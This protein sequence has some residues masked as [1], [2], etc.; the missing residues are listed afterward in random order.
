MSN[1]LTYL[2][3]IKAIKYTVLLYLIIA[4]ADKATMNGNTTPR[5]AAI[6]YL[7]L[8]QIAGSVIVEL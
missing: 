5:R 1:L 4:V 8:K 6:I 7:W 2:L 3:L